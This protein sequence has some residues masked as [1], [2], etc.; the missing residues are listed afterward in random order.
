MMKLFKRSKKKIRGI[1]KWVMNRNKYYKANKK[2]MKK[3]Q[4]KKKTN[5]LI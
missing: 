3:I 5:N 4:K 2:K 1:L